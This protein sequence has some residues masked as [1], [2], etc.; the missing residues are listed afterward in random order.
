RQNGPYI[1]A[2]SFPVLVR[3]VASPPPAAILTTTRDMSLMSFSFRTFGGLFA[4]VATLTFARS[5]G[6]AAQGVTTGAIGGAV[7]SEQGHGIADAQISISNPA[8]GFRTGV[9]TRENGQYFVQ[10]LEVGG[11]YTVVV[12]RIGMGQQTKT[13]VMVRLSQTT[14]V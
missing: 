11:P 10:G 5:T 2:Q 4:L 6:L 8:T 12:R 3:R 9:S 13:D 14:R 7:T 1:K